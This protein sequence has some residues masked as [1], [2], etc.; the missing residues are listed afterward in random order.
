MSFSTLQIVLLDVEQVQITALKSILDLLQTFGLEAFKVTPAEQAIVE[1]EESLLEHDGND[2]DSNSPGDQ[3]GEGDNEEG[4]DG[5]GKGDSNMIQEAQ[6]SVSSVF[7]VLIKLLDREVRLEFYLSWYTF[8]KV[9][10][11][12][13]EFYA[14]PSQRSYSTVK[15]HN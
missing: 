4:N 13:P 12:F 10:E 2:D 11:E 7:S 9:F 15:T 1:A 6:K 8:F 3:G 14:L 5:Q